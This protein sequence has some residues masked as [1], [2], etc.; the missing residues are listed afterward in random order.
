M[1][2]TYCAFNLSLQNLEE[3]H[4]LRVALESKVED[5]WSQFRQ[6]LNNYN[7]ST[8]ER[9]NHFENLKTKDEKSADEIEMQMRKLQRISDQIAQ[10]KAKMAQNTKE[11]EERNRKLKEEREQMMVHLQALKG[12]MNKLR[13]LQRER[14]TK[15][16]LESNEA[17]KQ[18]IL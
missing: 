18:V 10:L 6:A 4:A 8:E 15:M 2:K 1:T 17:I 7:E 12:Q 9:K 14:L 3:K 13:D 5:L 16:T 11:Y